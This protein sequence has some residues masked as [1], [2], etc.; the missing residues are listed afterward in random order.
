MLVGLFIFNNTAEAQTS[1]GEIMEV[2][3]MRVPNNTVIVIKEGTIV[4]VKEGTI[5]VVK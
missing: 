2:Q 5:V 4:V 1:K 3:S